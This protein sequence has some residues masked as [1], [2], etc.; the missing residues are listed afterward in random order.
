MKKKISWLLF[1]VIFVLFLAGCS[2][3]SNEASGSGVIELTVW[4]DWT[5]ERPENTAY[6][7]MIKQFN[8]EHEDIQVISESIPHDQYETKLR[9]QAAG[10]QL[11]DM[12]RVWPGAR[13]KPL[14]EGNAVLS[15]NPIMDNWRDKI[16]EGILKDYAF[17][18]EQYAIPANISETSLIFYNK[19]IIQQAGYNE[20]PSS[21][22]GLK[23]LI[24]EVNNMG[25][26]P[27]S[28]G[29][30][31]VWPLQSVYI[32]TIADRFTGS[33]FLPNTLEGEGT[34]ENGQFIK[35]LTVIQE[36]S[37]MDAFNV[38]MNTLDEAQSRNEFIAGNAAMHFAGSWAIGPILDNVENTDN[39]GVAPFPS[40]A[41]GEG[42][43]N[44]IAGVAGGGIAV[45][46][47]LSE[48]KQQAAFKFLK[49]FYGNQLYQEL[50]KAN[51]IVPVEVE[52]DGAPEVYKK[53]NS[54][55]Q[56]GLAPVYDA[57]LPP[58]VTDVI[59]NGLQSITLGE[60]TPEELAADMQEE[61]E[62]E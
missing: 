35:A 40:F 23:K 16:P 9:T 6:K 56:N 46:S 44:K 59:N 60:K 8:K 15:L 62:N 29:N 2:G 61:L 26:T 55:A 22:E 48:E 13:L 17:N 37:E 34:F 7:N 4:N 1:S 38:D 28:L 50:A 58:N 30:K 49:F 18:E 41:E 27:I 45:N 33:E 3:N 10:K 52:V 19:D 36:L 51:I 24:A 54:F 47:S 14:V 39:I 12:F 57:T 53:A 20:F 43:Q 11:P 32:S 25:T 42:N 21:Y 5:E 31:A